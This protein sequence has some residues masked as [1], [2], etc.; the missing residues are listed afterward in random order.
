MASTKS[1]VFAIWRLDSIRASRTAKLCF[2]R[3]PLLRWSPSTSTTDWTPP[4][5]PAAP[6]RKSNTTPNSGHLP[7]TGLPS[8]LLIGTLLP[9][10]FSFSPENRFKCF[11]NFTFFYFFF[12]SNNLILINSTWIAE[13]GAKWKPFWMKWSNC[14]STSFCNRHR[15]DWHLVPNEETHFSSTII[16]LSILC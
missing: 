11:P 10:F 15:T 1:K 6:S 14:W 12:L 8:V 4:S 7:P 3:P 16:D 9:V 13:I 2:R 5:E